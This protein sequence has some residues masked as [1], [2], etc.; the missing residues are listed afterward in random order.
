[1]LPPLWMVHL[2]FKAL[3]TLIPAY[4]RI[5]GELCSAF[6][7]VSFHLFIVFCAWNWTQGLPYTSEVS[8][9]WANLSGSA[10]GCLYWYF[11]EVGGNLCMKE[12]WSNKWVPPN[13][14]SSLNLLDLDLDSNNIPNMIWSHISWHLISS[15]CAN[16]LFRAISS[17]TLNIKRTML[18]EY[19]SP[20]LHPFPQ[21]FC[22]GLKSDAVGHL[23]ILSSLSHLWVTWIYPVDLAMMVSILIFLP[24]ERVVEAVSSLRQ[25]QVLRRIP[26][27]QRSWNCMHWQWLLFLS[28]PFW[29]CLVI[30]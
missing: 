8:H 19:C 23:Q 24:A 12:L 3:I 5:S 7:F 10:S 4:S 25:L 28:S 20:M 18:L 15:C 27:A 6:S 21:G 30:L 13:M 9:Q 16:V 1:M 14:V 29:G 22:Q 2:Y 26:S 17:S 11:Q